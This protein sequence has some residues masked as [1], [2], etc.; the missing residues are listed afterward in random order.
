MLE[1]KAPNI[2]N[3]KKN[4]RLGDTPMPLVQQ[5][6][7]SPSLSSIQLKESHSEP[8][9]LPSAPDNQTGL[10]N[11]LKSGI[12]HL[13][14]ISLDDIKV[15]YNSSQPAQLRAHAFAQ[16]TDIHIAPGQEK[17]LSHEAWHVVQQKQGRVKPTIQVNGNVPVN[18]DMGLES[19]ADVMGAKALKIESK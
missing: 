19:E 8:L 5:L 15:H 7:S 12:E 10:P 14:G 16:G 2:V 9:H 4:V 18:D 17:H 3:T 1:N 13:S 6:K 11:Q